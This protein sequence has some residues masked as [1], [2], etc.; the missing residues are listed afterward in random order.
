MSTSLALDAGEPALE[1]PLAVHRLA[2]H[3][4]RAGGRRTADSRRAP[5]SGRS[6]PGDDTSSVY[7]VG[8][9]SSTSRIALRSRLTL[10]AILDAD[11]LLRRRRRARADRSAPAAPC[12][13]L[14]GGTAR[15]RSRARSRRPPAPAIART[16]STTVASR[17]HKLK[18]WAHAHSVLTKGLRIQKYSTCP[19]SGP[20]PNSR[21]T[22]TRVLARRTSN[23]RLQRPGRA[24]AGRSRAAPTIS[25]S[26]KSPGAVERDGSHSVR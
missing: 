6:S 16:C 23:R 11:A 22:P 2:H 20:K 24:N 7:A 14:R 17:A 19:T 21:H 18:K 13:A 1:K 10:R 9:T 15:R 26:T 3:D 25:T 12:R 4:L 8:T 5:R